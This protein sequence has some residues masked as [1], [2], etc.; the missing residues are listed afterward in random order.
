M[1]GIDGFG[2]LFAGTNTQDGHPFR[3]WLFQPGMGYGEWE[4]WWPAPGQKRPRAHEGID[5]FCYEDGRDRIHS[6]AQS[7]VPM[8][9][10]AV[11]IALCTDFLGQSVF[12][13]PDQLAPKRGI[14]VLAHMAPCVQVGQRLQQ[15]DIVGRVAATSGEVPAHLH[16]SFLEGDWRDLPA[17]LSWPALLGQQKLR[18]VRPFLI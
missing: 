2:V 6:V 16:V 17:K 10:R 3:R 11:V 15:G 8:P 1:K 5:F 7:L 14:L 18:F 4:F 13:L 12:L 9:S